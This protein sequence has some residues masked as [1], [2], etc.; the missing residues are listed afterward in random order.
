MTTNDMM[1]VPLPSFIPSFYPI[2]NQQS[3]Q[4]TGTY[5][6]IYSSSPQMS[7]PVGKQ[8][9][10]WADSQ[11]MAIYFQIFLANIFI[12]PTLLKELSQSST[13]P[14]QMAQ[15]PN[16]QSLLIGQSNQSLPLTLTI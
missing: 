6:T 13:S 9:A 15:L 8:T 12:F 3:L 7:T 16:I 2:T 4:A 5:T 11:F 1:N 14:L 10:W